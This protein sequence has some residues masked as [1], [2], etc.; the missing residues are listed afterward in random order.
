MK[1]GYV[2]EQNNDDTVTDESF[3]IAESRN[4]HV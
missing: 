1:L 3:L 2:Y 4:L